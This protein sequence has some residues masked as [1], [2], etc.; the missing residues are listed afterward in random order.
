VEA[1]VAISILATYNFVYYAMARRALKLI[2][3]E[4][5]GPDA[6]LKTGM[7]TSIKLI[8]MIFNPALPREDQPKQLK[9]LLRTSR[10]MLYAA[11]LVFFLV[12]LLL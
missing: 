9:V 8:S 3:R 10:V 5:D 1:R 7:S 2:A 4:S 6:T 11:P 12:F